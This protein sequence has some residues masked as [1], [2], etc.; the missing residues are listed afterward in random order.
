MEEE[1]G[2]ARE[3]SIE[4]IF[5]IYIVSYNKKNPDKNVKAHC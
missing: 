2:T 4:F 1:K 5:T 3:L